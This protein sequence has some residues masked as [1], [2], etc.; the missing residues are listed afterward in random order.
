MTRK[1]IIASLQL[2][3]FFLCTPLSYSEDVFLTIDSGSGAPGS[4]NIPITVTLDNAAD[5]VKGVSFQ[6]HDRGNYLKVAGCEGIGRASGLSCYYNDKSGYATINLISMGDVIQ[7]GNGPILEIYFN[8]SEK[9]SPG[10][11]IA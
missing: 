1:I 6:I 10:E 4:K 11:S 8:V 5:R 2:C 9:A 3:F 7:E